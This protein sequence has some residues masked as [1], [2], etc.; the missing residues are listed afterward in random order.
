MYKI[1]I[2]GK[3]LDLSL[4]ADIEMSERIRA[5]QNTKAVVNCYCHQ[6][7]GCPAPSRPL[8]LT[9]VRGGTE[10]HLRRDKDNGDMHHADCRHHTL[11][12][13]GLASIGLSMDALRTGEDG[14][15]RISLDFGLGEKDGGDKPVNAVH[16][17]LANGRKSQIRSRASLFGLLHLL[18][19]RAELNRHDPR[20]PEPIDGPWER[21]RKVS[22]HIFPNGMRSL[23]EHG[24]SGILLLPNNATSSP[25]EQAKRNW[26]KLR[27]AHKL[28][29]VMFLCQ[30]DPQLLTGRNAGGY[31][32]LFDLFGVGMSLHGDLIAQMLNEYPAERVALA[33]DEPVI[34]FGIAKVRQLDRGKLAA[35]VER[36]SLMGV[37]NW[38]VPVESSHERRVAEHLE[39][40]G[41]A[42]VKPLRHDANEPV[43]PDFVLLDTVLPTPLEV[44]GM[45]TPLY[46]E[47]KAE[48]QAYYVVS[49][50]GRHWQWDVLSEEFSV[51]IQRLQ[52]P[53]SILNS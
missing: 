7:R 25:G 21:I 50:P 37:T 48:K 11:T 28:R 17:L 6:S 22:R 32:E 14:E 38:Y 35:T 46:L 53:N 4:L 49:F 44:Y 9:P 15:L 47:R 2:N 20:N 16:H 40:N 1:A 31:A 19:T 13:D 45:S 33:A 42:Y 39:A 36:I 18:W 43:H 3:L 30:L 29:R 26:S 10:Y 24:L 51:A 27:E 34:A 52:T 23:S 12:A 5:A 8:R 41:R